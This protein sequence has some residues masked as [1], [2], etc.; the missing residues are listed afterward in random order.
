MAGGREETGTTQAD[1]CDEGRTVR[2]G[3]FTRRLGRRARAPLRPRRGGMGPCRRGPLQLAIT[4]G[5]QSEDDA[6]PQRHG[7]QM[8]TTLRREFWRGEGETLSGDALVPVGTRDK[9]CSV[10]TAALSLHPSASAVA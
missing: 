7:L 2:G 4:L 9:A 8:A 10:T 5:A 6:I 3:S 1:V